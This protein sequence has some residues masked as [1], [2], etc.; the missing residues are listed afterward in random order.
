MKEYCVSCLRI[1]FKVLNV[2]MCQKKLVKVRYQKWTLFLFVITHTLNITRLVE[3][4]SLMKC[5]IRMS[6]KFKNSFFFYNFFWH[7]CI[8]RAF[9]SNVMV[10]VNF[11]S[12]IL[13]NIGKFNYKSSSLFYS[14]NLH[15]DL[16][17]W[18][19]SHIFE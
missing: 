13:H 19:E 6:K 12:Q 14:G 4:E 8:F 17:I 7:Y 2:P 1:L 10:V 5:G 16:K 18:V 11:L 9:N 3:I 15:L